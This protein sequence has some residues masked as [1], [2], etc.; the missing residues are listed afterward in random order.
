MTRIDPINAAMDDFAENLRALAVDLAT[1]TLSDEG[2]TEE[3]KDR[4]R[5]FIQF[6]TLEGECFTAY[7]QTK[8]TM[9][10]VNDA[11][12]ARKGVSDVVETLSVA[13]RASLGAIL[14]A[15]LRDVMA[16]CNFLARGEALMN[17]L[18]HEFGTAP[19][20]QSI[21]GL[22]DMRDGFKNLQ[23]KADALLAL[24]TAVAPDAS[25]AE[26]IFRF[27]RPNEASEYIAQAHAAEA[28]ATAGGAAAIAS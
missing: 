17:G 11:I 3:D 18:I 28:R 6:T 24:W 14:I 13:N 9:N 4:A 21:G 15:T 5:K 16:V 1:K 22:T 10:K 12:Q 19:H 27:L 23:G 8:E 7:S 20:D 25:N 26:T 2:A